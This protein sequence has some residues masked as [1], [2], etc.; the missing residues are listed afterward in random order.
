[1]FGALQLADIPSMVYSCLTPGVLG[2]GSGS[3]VTLAKTKRWLKIDLKLTNL[4]S[5]RSVIQFDFQSLLIS[6]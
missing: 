6:V 3:I 4:N 2:I 1:M 5:N